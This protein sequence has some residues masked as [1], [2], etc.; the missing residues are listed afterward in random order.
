M[1]LLLL[2]AVVVVVVVYVYNSSFILVNTD[3]GQCAP[4]KK[5]QLLTTLKQA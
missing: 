3:V 2:L 1:M 4:Y 5:Q